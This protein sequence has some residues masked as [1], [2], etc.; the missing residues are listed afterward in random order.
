MTKFLSLRLA[1]SNLLKNRSSYFPF[2]FASA[3]LVFTVYTFASMAL[4]RGLAQFAGTIFSFMLILGLVIV[5]FFAAIFLFYANSFLIKRRK[6]ELGLYSILGMEKRHIAKVL[7]WELT[8]S[9]FLSTII[10]LL[11]GLLLSRLL[12]L[13][14]QWLLQTPTPLSSQ[15]NPYALL[16]TAL[17][18]AALFFLLKLYNTWQ[19]RSV[20]PLALLQGSQVGEKEPKSRWP[21]AI[22]GFV[23]L[24]AGYVLAQ[25]VKNPITAMVIFFAAV[26]LV[27][28]G[29]YCLFMAG[30]LT[31]LKLLKNNKKFYYQSRHFITVSGMLYRMK[32]NAAG[33]ASIAILC[34]MAMVT[35]GT[36]VA[37]YSGSEK[38]LSEMYPHDL[39]ITCPSAEAM[40]RT[41]TA[42]QDCA[43][44]TGMA[45]S[46]LK[47]FESYQVALGLKNGRLWTNDNLRQMGLDEA[48]TLLDAFLL[49]EAS[50]AQ[51]QGE[52]LGLPE[53]TI[54]WDTSSFP[55]PQPISIQGVAYSFQPLPPS[56][57]RL[58]MTVLSA[59]RAACLVV[60][61]EAA[62]TQLLQALG[63][64]PEDFSHPVYTVQTN[65]A[66]GEEAQDAYVAA[67][68]NRLPAEDTRHLI[69]KSTQRAGLLSLYG[70]FLF[71]GLF[72]G[73]LF[74]MATGL[75]I[76]FKQISEGYQD[77]DRFII[78][79]QVGMS[80]K[81]VRGTVRSQIL[82]VFFL[83]LAVAVCHVAGSLHMMI[84]MLQAFSLV[85]AAFVTL[86]AFLAAAGIG[87]L[88]AFFYLR[89]AKT[90]YRMVRF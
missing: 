17:L 43:V 34:T 42:V 49:T 60:R 40:E 83:P 67:L 89:T 48:N 53:N 44:E 12:F 13:L 18:F 62:A 52:P 16:G 8:I 2:L 31:V 26:L 84:L 88:Y 54:G 10:G 7:R 80:Q 70:G 71:V 45:L 59:A 11:L 37:L 77:H 72:L 29:T 6:K 51:L 38:M 30:S 3:M 56:H 39:L 22:L 74:M 68:K 21:L 50:Y 79:Q 86:N 85:D 90:Y 57:F 33:L 55:L 76:Y 46:D 69:Q 20:S 23:C 64:T 73:L 27:I 24:L 81:E 63:A 61:D 14:V 15:W 82:L 4:N 32:Q 75:I 47:A 58:S 78:L 87:A 65:V 66:G 5:C 36:T 1:C 35:V 28:I 19:V 25:W 41:R 9:W